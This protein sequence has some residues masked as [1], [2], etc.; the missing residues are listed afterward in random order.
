MLKYL[1]CKE[2]FSEVPNEISLGISIS[3]CKLHCKECHSKELWE[4]EGTPLTIEELDRLIQRHTGIT[5]I[6]FLGGEHNIDSLSSLF[7]YVFTNTKLK[8]AWYCGLDVIPKRKTSVCRYLHYVKIGHYDEK[9]G[10]LNNP[11]TNQRLYRL[12]HNGDGT[13]WQTDITQL[14]QKQQKQ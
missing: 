4:D 5:C 1:Y 9:L 2:V 8:V 12:D 10:P 3:G 6:L 13:Y 14:L 11:T 7:E